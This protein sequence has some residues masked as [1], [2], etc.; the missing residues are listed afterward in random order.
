MAASRTRVELLQGTLNLLILR[1]LLFGPQ[2]G[3]GIGKHIRAMSEDVLRVE[4]DR[5]TRRSTG[6]R[7]R[8]GSRPNGSSRTRASAPVLQTHAFRTGTADCRA[9]EVGRV[10]GGDGACAAAGAVGGYT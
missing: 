10:V 8:G 5:S 6:W 4:S 2:H 9:V 1:T 7:R 3:H